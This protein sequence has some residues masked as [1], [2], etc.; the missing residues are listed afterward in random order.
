[1]KRDFRPQ[2]ILCSAVPPFPGRRLVRTD[3]GEKEITDLP[4]IRS[5]S[6]HRLS[7]HL[8]NNKANGE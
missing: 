1:M 5:L 6:A 7:V 8:T 4:T 3:G 2:L